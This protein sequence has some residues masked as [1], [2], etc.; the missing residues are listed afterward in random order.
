MGKIKISILLGII[1]LFSGCVSYKS[2]KPIYP[3]PSQKVNSLSPAFTWEPAKGVKQYDFAI[4]EAHDTVR[5]GGFFY[6]LLLGGLANYDLGDSYRVSNMAILV[7]DIE[8]T[9]FKPD[10][11]LK[12]SLKNYSRPYY[13]SVRPSGQTEWASVRSGGTT[14]YFLFFTPREDE[15]DISNKEMK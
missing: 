5:G 7:K 6:H 12:P 14:E 11:V 13:W 3:H 4:W 1:F 8:G 15:L 9:E 10:V 2:I